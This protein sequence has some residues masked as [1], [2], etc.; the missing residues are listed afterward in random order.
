[1]KSL[2]KIKSV[3]AASVLVAASASG[4]ANAAYIDAFGQPSSVVLTAFDFVQNVGY[5]RDLGVTY[6]VFYANLS[7]GNAL[8]GMNLAGDTKFTNIFA[9]S[10]VN[11]IQ[12]NISAGLDV[13]AADDRMLTTAKNDVTPVLNNAT[14]NS[15]L[16]DISIFFGNLNG[17][18]CAG[19]IVCSGTGSESGNA[20]VWYGD[21]FNKTITTFNN[22]GSINNAAV[23]KTNKILDIYVM[24]KVLGVPNFF[25]DR[26]YEPGLNTTVESFDAN[27]QLAADGTLSAVPLPP[28]VWMF[29]AGLMGFIGIGR[30]R[31]TQA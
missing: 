17:G 11:D 2:K 20:A 13:L 1:M 7:S 27:L 28:A 6:D 31:K 26:T 19:A 29:G 8:A 4:I 30:R 5:V 3:L 12:W 18:Q 9:G 21:K 15:V 14:T 24:S 22:S 16:G 25:G 23:T 10:Q